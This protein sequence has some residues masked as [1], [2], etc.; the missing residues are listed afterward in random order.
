[1]AVTSQ[2]LLGLEKLTLDKIATLKPF[3]AFAGLK[4][5][6]LRLRRLVDPKRGGLNFHAVLQLHVM[7]QKPNRKIDAARRFDVGGL[8]EVQD[9][10]RLVQRSCY[11]LV[12]GKGF[13]HT[14]P[15]LRKIHFDFE[16]INFRNPSEPKPSTH[17][18]FGGE[19]L[20]QWAGGKGYTMNQM[21]QL[22][23]WFEKPRIPCFP[24]C[25]AL[26][27]DWI[28]LEFSHNRFAKAVLDNS[29]WNAHVRDAE[30]IIIEPFLQNCQDFIQKAKV[31]KN[32]WLHH[33]VYEMSA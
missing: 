26:L 12:I 21:H 17:I 22:S 29:D 5:E 32:R 31:T 13:D 9:P 10:S 8:I 16:P 28:F 24:T 2:Q 11:Q 14:K 4:A 25:L 6:A 33:Q 1:M 19:L 23:P 27:L 18:Q 15:V 7:E 3:D 30:G 20:P